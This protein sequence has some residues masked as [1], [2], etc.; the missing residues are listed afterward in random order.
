MTLETPNIPA[1]GLPAQRALPERGLRPLTFC[2]M[3][4]LVFLADQ[5]SKAWIQRT[6]QWEHTRRILGDVFALTLT[7]N[8]GGAWGILP[9]GNP[10]FIVFAA[11]AVVALLFAYHRLGRLELTVG[12]AFALALGG[13]LGNL[14]D[15]LH[16]GYVVDFF[17]V[18][19]I[20]YQWPVFN[21]ADS[22][23][24]VSILLLLWHFFRPPKPETARADVRDVPAP[25]TTVAP[26]AAEDAAS[27]HSE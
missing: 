18:R 16:Y 8:S 10:V 19:I 1:E 9:K 24:T 20:H 17:A 6:L 22:A 7:N 13:A 26:L 2:L 23:I 5:V 14:L 3:V 21:I 12:S 15:R 4:A 25:P 11:V 27:G